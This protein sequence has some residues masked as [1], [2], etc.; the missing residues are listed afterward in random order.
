MSIAWYFDFISPFA[1]LHWPKVRALMAEREV[2]PVPIL[3]AAILDAHGQK[4]PAE[5][6]GKREFTYRHVLWQARREGV[7]LRAPPAHP[8]NPIPALR[9]CIAAGNTPAAI[10]AIYDWIWA[11]GQAGDSAAAL[12]PVMQALGVAPEQLS[13]DAVKAALRANTDAA[14]AAGVFGVP[15]LAID[16]TLFWGN[17]VH[18]FALAV[19]RDP[20]LLDDPEMRRIDRLPVG[21]QRN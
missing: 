4:G 11:Q 15:T 6:S 18:D 3:F 16:G 2:V 12:Q 14:L 13:S 1:Y 17:D 9:L 7:A 20:G 5:I 10:T 19:L 21:V 8:F